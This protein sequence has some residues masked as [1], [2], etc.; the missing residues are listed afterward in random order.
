MNIKKGMAIIKKNNITYYKDIYVHYIIYEYLSDEVKWW[1]NINEQDEKLFYNNDNIHKIV[2]LSYDDIKNEMKK[3]YKVYFK[4]K[5]SSYYKYI[6]DFKNI[7][8]EK[9]IPDSKDYNYCEF[10]NIKKR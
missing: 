3:G 7:N 5:Y 10:Y 8:W 1:F 6:K 2:N 4:F 9:C